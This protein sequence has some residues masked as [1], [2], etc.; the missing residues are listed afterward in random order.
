MDVRRHHKTRVTHVRTAEDVLSDC[1]E[2]REALDK[3]SKV[4]KVTLSTLILEKKERVEK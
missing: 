2:S 3:E 1:P 4:R